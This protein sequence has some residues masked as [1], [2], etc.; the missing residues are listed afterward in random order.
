MFRAMVEH[1]G[2]CQNCH[3]KQ[4]RLMLNDGF[5]LMD[6][7]NILMLVGDGNYT[8]LTTH[9]GTEI[10]VCRNL[11]WFEQRLPLCF[12]RPNQSQMV[13]LHFLTGIKEGYLCFCKELPYK[14]QVKKAY[15][16]RFYARL[17]RWDID[18]EIQAPIAAPIAMPTA[19]QMIQIL[20]VIQALQALQSPPPK[21]DM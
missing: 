18:H 4:K 12:A 6:I 7:A 3:P 19:D 16:Q 14:C 2:H 8:Y 9:S 13:N 5:E 17:N 11:G 20:Q 15:A 21:S 10:T 1:T